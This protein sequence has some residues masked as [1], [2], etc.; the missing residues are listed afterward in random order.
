M[1]PETYANLVDLV[2]SVAPLVLAAAAA[3]VLRDLAAVLVVLDGADRAIVNQFHSSAVPS[4]YS[5]AYASLLSLK[6][7][8]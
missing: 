8:D 6:S 3:D 4:R 2:P 5:I 7:V 1:V